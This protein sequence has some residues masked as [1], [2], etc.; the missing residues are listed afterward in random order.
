MG[1]QV[2]AFEGMRTQLRLHGCSSAGSFEVV[3]S[4]LERLIARL[5]GQEDI[6]WY[7]CD[8]MSLEEQGLKTS[9]LTS[10]G[11]ARNIPLPKSSSENEVA[12]DNIG[13]ERDHPISLH[14]TPTTAPQDPR[15]QHANT[16]PKE[17]KTSNY[18]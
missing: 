5:N 2:K 1:A 18:G 11:A 7:P 14:N 16:R 3:Q 13:N 15:Y 4:R 10:L 9:T 6:P 17:G 12:N 8:K